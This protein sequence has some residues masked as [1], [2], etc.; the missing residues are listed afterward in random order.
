M[1]K[2][3]I[4]EDLNSFLLFDLF[5]N[6]NLFVKYTGIPN[7][8][9]LIILPETKYPEI[10]NMVMYFLDME[11]NFIIETKK[12]DLLFNNLILRLV[13]NVKC[14][15]VEVLARKIPSGNMGRF[16]KWVVYEPSEKD[17]ILSQ[18]I[19]EKKY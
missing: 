7:Q 5:D 3:F 13:C 12:N 18:I 11:D 4:A 8:N 1:K 17:Y 10:V 15:Y 9:S 14:S 6:K 16:E 2:L 19:F